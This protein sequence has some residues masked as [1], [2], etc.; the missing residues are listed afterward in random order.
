MP[1]SAIEDDLRATKRPSSESWK[2]PTA[3]VHLRAQV[4]Y[5]IIFY[6]LSTD[7]LLNL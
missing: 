3:P 1:R 7:T 4:K 6:V 2:E 5:N